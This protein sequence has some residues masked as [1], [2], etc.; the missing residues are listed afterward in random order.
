MFWQRCLSVS[1][2]A[3]ILYSGGFQELQP[4]SRGVA[5]MQHVSQ[6]K[7]SLAPNIYKF[8]SLVM[9]RSTLPCWICAFVFGHVNCGVVLLWYIPVQQ[10]VLGAQHAR[11]VT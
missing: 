4:V 3:R 2:R 8:I 9:H 6:G 1:P 5:T 10:K 11:H 7:P